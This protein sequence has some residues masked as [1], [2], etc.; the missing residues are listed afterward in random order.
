MED[1]DKVG[2]D[3]RSLGYGDIGRDLECLVVILR[4]SMLRRMYLGKKA[5]LGDSISL[6]ASLLRCLPHVS[7]DL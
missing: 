1:S 7:K 3:S 4:R 2:R 6:M 5:F